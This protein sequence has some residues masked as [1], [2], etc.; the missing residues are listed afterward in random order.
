MT[1]NESDRR[2]ARTWY[3][4]FS[5]RD[6]V[7]AGLAGVTVAISRMAGFNDAGA[8]ASQSAT[9]ASL[10]PMALGVYL[11]EATWKPEIFET[12]STSIRRTPDYLVLYEQWANGEFGQ[13]QRG[14][15]QVIDRL[16]VTPVIAW[17]PYDANADPI[18]QPA[19][20]LANIVRGD[21]DDYVDSWAEGLA[22]YGKPVFLSFAHEMNGDWLPWGV[23]VN[24]NAPGDYVAAWRHVHDRFTAAGASNVR[25][26]WTPNELYEGIPATVAE[27]YPGDEYV[28]WFGVNGFNWGAAIHWRSCDCQSAWRTFAEIFDYTYQQLTALSSKPIMILETAS[29]EVGG[30]KAAWISDALLE[31][32]PTNFPGIRAITWFNNVTTGLEMIEGGVVVPTAAVDWPVKSSPAALEAFTEAVNTPYLQGSLIGPS[33]G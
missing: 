27:V 5:R 3:L 29:S 9:D 14:Q 8:S 20:R 32:L 7:R 26:L 18:N 10:A 16:G 28:D 11:P 31:Q 22:T 13:D 2:N 19:Y 25:W 1:S 21:F 30:D 15:L 12:F 6:V 17:E 24:G 4:P 23:G 33:L